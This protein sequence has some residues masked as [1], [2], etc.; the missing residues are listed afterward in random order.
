MAWNREK[1]RKAAK[2]MSLASGILGIVFILF[3]CIVV[4]FMGAW[5]MLLFGIPLLGMQLYRLYVFI[6]LG[7]DEKQSRK[8]T[9][10]WDRPAETAAP[11]REISSGQRFCPY[12]GFSLEENYAFCPKC[13]RKQA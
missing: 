1:E 2:K 3:W 10:P 6:Q 9:E 5:P 4:V 12:C 7:N 8:E 11:G 13:G